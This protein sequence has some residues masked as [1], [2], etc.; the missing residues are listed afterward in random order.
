MPYRG[1]ALSVLAAITLAACLVPEKFTAKVEFHPDASYDYQFVGTA[2][3]PLGLMELR[4]H[5]SI[6]ARTEF[7]LKNDGDRM[8]KLMDVTSARYLGNARYD[9]SIAGHR[10]P[11]EASH[12]IDILS[13]VSGKDGTITVSTTPLKDQDRQELAALG[14]K[15]DGTLEIKLPSNA[16][17]ISQNAQSVPSLFGTAGSYTWK[18]GAPDQRPLIRFKFG[19]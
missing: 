2:S 14:I 9:L 1:F 6:S 16:N 13:V 7:A 17:V 4:Q 8:P 18:I 3:N 11:G 5:G 19:K 12:L 15:M 10:K